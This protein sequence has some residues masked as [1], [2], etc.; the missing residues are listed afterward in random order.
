[1]KKSEKLSGNTSE[2]MVSIIAP[3]FNEIENIDNFYNRLEKMCASWNRNHEIIF[4][5][6]GSSDGTTEY[7]RALPQR[8]PVV[9]VIRFARNFGQENAIIAGVDHARGDIIQFIDV[10][11]QVIPEDIPR[12]IAKIDEGYDLVAGCRPR[13]EETLFLRRIPSKFANFVFKNFFHLP[14]GDLGCG[15]QAIR[16][17][18]FEGVDPFSALYTYRVL[19]AGWRG[20]KYTD[21]QVEYNPRVAG[22][23][24]YNF[25]SLL[26]L[27]L[28][29]VVTFTLRQ[30]ELVIFFLTGSISAGLGVVGL[31]VQI[32]RRLFGYSFSAAYFNLNLFFVFSGMIFIMFGL[33]NERINRIN[34]Q[35]NKTPVY[36]I[37]EIWDAATKKN[38]E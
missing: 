27:F 31:F 4:V 6:D 17:R 24:K 9:R 26:H 14:Y 30:Y 5:D 13:R 29:L 25:M 16:K 11:L 7:L 28:N 2:L 15:I 34:H 22:E 19:F 35:I 1:M 37:D 32:I 23:A 8:N 36:V 20:S 3:V 12:L 33:L 38:S 21:I 18:L 10:D